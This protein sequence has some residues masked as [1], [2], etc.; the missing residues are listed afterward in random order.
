ML[1]KLDT[2]QSHFLQSLDNKQIKKLSDSISDNLCFVSVDKKEILMYI[3]TPKIQNQHLSALW[4]D[5]SSIVFS[6]NLLFEHLW[7]N[8][9]FYNLEYSLNKNDLI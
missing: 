5:S 8:S 9:N 6:N 7:E 3:K 1:S 2:N 4:T